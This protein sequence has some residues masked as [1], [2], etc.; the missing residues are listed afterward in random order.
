MS[1][2]G[3]SKTVEQMPLAS[4]REG[5]INTKVRANGRKIVVL[6]RGGELRC[7]DEVCSH[8]GGDLSEADYDPVR[9]TLACRW[10]GYVYSADDGRFLENPN[11][12]LMGTL[13]QPSRHYDPE[14]TV[15]GRLT[16]VPCRLVRDMIEFDPEDE[17]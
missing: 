10:H 13:R 2:D 9:G 5:Q 17:S 15:G 16:R 6:R 3:R 8:M 4:V 7:F 1:S 12:K 11:E 14:K